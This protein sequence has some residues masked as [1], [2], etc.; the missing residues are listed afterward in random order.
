[1]VFIVTHSVVAALIYRK[2]LS[3]VTT[4]HNRLGLFVSKYIRHELVAKINDKMRLHTC[5][6]LG[7]YSVDYSRAHRVPVP[8]SMPRPTLAW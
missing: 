3:R 4:S 1:V 6:A 2:D 8:I 7:R 5:E